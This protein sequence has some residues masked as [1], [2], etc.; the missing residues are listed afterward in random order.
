LSS[1]RAEGEEGTVCA[2]V[3]RAV[4]GLQWF[5]NDGGVTSWRGAGEGKVCESA[6]LGTFDGEGPPPP[7]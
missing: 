4:A 1:A 6:K 3:R 5:C 2:L 7:L